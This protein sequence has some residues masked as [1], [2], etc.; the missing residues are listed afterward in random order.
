MTLT[1]D[2]DGWYA[3]VPTNT[4]ILGAAKLTGKTQRRPFSRFR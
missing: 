1:R 2:E 4:T 3:K